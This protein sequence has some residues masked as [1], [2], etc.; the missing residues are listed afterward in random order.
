MC[1][2]SHVVIAIGSESIRGIILSKI[3]SMTNKHFFTWFFF[4]KYMC[5]QIQYT[6][7][8][9]C[10]IIENMILLIFNI[11]IYAYRQSYL[12]I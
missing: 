7:N 2:V 5:I 12:D 4:F 10:K 3:F 1:I 11:Y 6:Y 8:F 9:F